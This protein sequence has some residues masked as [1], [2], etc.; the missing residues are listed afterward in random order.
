MIFKHILARS[1]ASRSWNSFKNNL[2]NAWNN[3]QRRPLEA[4]Q[5]SCS[6]SCWLR[7]DSNNNRCLSFIRRYCIIC[8]WINKKMLSWQVQVIQKHVQL[9]IPVR[10]WIIPKRSSSSLPIIKKLIYNNP[11]KHISH[12][13][14]RRIPKII[15]FR[16]PNK[17]N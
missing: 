11:T 16:L 6:L 17:I 5:N 3:C 2:N 7:K 1:L 15:T 12:R 4:E 10:I 13:K 9:K 8:R 14:R